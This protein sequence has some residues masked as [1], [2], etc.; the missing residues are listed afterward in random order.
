MSC[1][2]YWWNHDYACRKSGKD[3]NED[4]YYKYCRNYNYDSCPIY[5]QELPSDSSCYL[6]TACIRA[7]QLPDDCRELTTLRHFR[8][9]YVKSLPDGEAV[10]RHYYA[11]APKIV[12]AIQATP[13]AQAVFCAIYEQLI[14][15]CVEQIG[16]GEY[17]AAYER[18]KNATLALER[19]YLKAA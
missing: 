6:T 2:F 16:R 11:V 8:D 9:T 19:R 1:P 3:V 10:V 4:I 5:K 18:Y 12:A 15:P 17:A 13:A 7:R 14:L